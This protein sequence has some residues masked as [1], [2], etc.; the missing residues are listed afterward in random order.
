MKKLINAKWL[1][2][3]VIMFSLTTVNADAQRRS[4]RR[5][6]RTGRT[7]RRA[8]RPSLANVQVLDEGGYTNIRATPGGRVVGKVRDGSYI[9]VNSNDLIDHPTWIRTYT[10]SG[11]FR[12]Y[13]HYTKL[14]TEYGLSEF[15]GGTSW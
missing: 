7:V 2:L 13:I 11:S 15:G 3:F 1:L 12:G 9:K 10:S 6:Y 8:S 4:G 5:S 14:N